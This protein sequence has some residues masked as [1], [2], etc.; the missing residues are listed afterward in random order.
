MTSAQ[1][2]EDI[3][4]F[5]KKIFEQIGKTQPSAFN[6]SF[7]SGKIMEWSMQFPTF[8][9]DMFR[10]VDVLP[11]LNSSRSIA[12]HVS[13]YLKDSAKEIHGL[14]SWG[15][16]VP[17]DSLRAK[18]TSFAVKQG[19]GQMA[20][21]FIAGETPKQALKEL[22]RLRNSRLAF[23][24]DLLGEY[25]LSEKEA[26]EYFNRYVEALQV[27]GDTVPGWPSAQPILPG[28]PGDRTAI[29]VSVKLSALYSQCYSL[30]YKKSVEVLSQRL[31]QLVRIAQEKDVQIY[32]DAEDTGHNGIIYQVF[33]E[34]FGSEEFRSYPYPGIVVQAY[35]KNSM[36]L[37]K[38]LLGLAKERGGPI[39]IRLVKGAYWDAETVSCSQR[40][41]ENPLYTQKYESDKNYEEISQLLL[42]N[43]D[44]VLPAFGSHNIRSLSHACVFAAQHNIPKN[45]FEL[46]MLY[47]MA[48]PIAKAFE[49]EGYLVRLY[50]PLG[51]LIPGMGYLVRR[52]LENTSNESF[53]RH[54]FYDDKAIDELLIAPGTL[55]KNG[56]PS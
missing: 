55:K 48:E 47:G 37:T 49:K 23:T 54:T 25:C 31:S 50:V 8:K 2:E 17:P 20:K 30:N 7:W 24:V 10:L 21:Q 4:V 3:K 33:R 6:T 19:V 39:A 14:A 45:Q 38:S 13:E 35:A 36:A 9:T 42:S 28:H 56:V 15:V 29:C 40:N 12:A 52:L 11:T 5:G 18:A 27:F 32:C 41:W 43:L 34:V 51:E 26:D 16:N 46:Q 44:H 1:L 53:L 22:K